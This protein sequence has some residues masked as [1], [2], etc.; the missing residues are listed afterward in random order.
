M[1]LPG[2]EAFISS[3]PGK[4]KTLSNIAFVLLLCNCGMALVAIT[5][6]RMGINLIAQWR[7]QHY[8]LKR[9]NGTNVALSHRVTMSK[10]QI[11]RQHFYIHLLGLHF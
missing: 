7:G 8:G 5:C 9:T 10:C 2:P 4:P 6:E 1:F 11:Y 3:R